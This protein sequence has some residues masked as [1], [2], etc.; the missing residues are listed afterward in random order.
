MSILILGSS[1]R[2]GRHLVEYFINEN[3]FVYAHYFKNE[4]NFNSKNVKNITFDINK[5]DNINLNYLKDIKYVINCI[6]EL[7][8]KSKIYE[9]NS[10]SLLFFLQKIKKINSNN[11]ISWIQ[12]SSIGVYGN[13]KEIKIDEKTKCY[14]N[15]DYE[16]SKYQFENILKL[17]SSDKSLKYVILRPSIIYGPNIR[18]NVLNG[19]LKIA[20]CHFFII[21]KN[22]HHSCPF[23]D[24]REVCEIVLQ[25]IKKNLVYNETFN[26]SKNYK[27]EDVKYA[28][29]KKINKKIYV[30]YLNN[31]FIII[32]FYI[33]RFFSSKMKDSVLSFF[34]STKKYSNSKITNLLN[35]KSNYDLI[36]FIKKVTI[37]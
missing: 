5:P 9:T 32:F 13:S 21:P 18:N 3:Y 27:I 8:N 23:I 4:I 35:Y 7:N 30:F 12:I 28:I 24:V 33:I 37:K 20:K 25:I 31:F 10:K 17:E 1:G 26:I 29:E 14:P 2:L 15:N 36:E 6:G 11:N 22:K 19:L 16:K 34:L